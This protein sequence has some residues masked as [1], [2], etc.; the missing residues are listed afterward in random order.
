MHRTVVINVVGLTRSLLG[1]HTPNLNKLLEQST[2]IEPVTPAVTCSAQ[3]TYL[4]GKPPREHGIVGNGWY[5]REMNEVWLWRQSNQ[6]IQ[7]PKV[8]HMARERDPA[9]TCSNTFWWYAMATDAD[10]TLT[11]RP[12]YL[13]DGRKMPDCYTCPLELRE[14]LSEKLGTFPL[15]HFWGPATTI[16]SSQWIADAAKY[17]E[18][19]HKP[20]LQLVYLPH[21][22]YVLQ[23]EGPDGDIGGDLE[24]IDALVGDLLEYF[25]A[26]DCRVMVLSEYGIQNVRRALHPNRMLR[27]AGLLSLKVDLGKEYLDFFS[28]R[29][30]AV[31]DHQIAHIYIHNPEDIPAVRK[32][33]EGVPGIHRVLD[34]TEQ[35]DIG[36]DHERSGELVLL[37]E[38]DTWF[39]YYYWQD[40]DR[41]PDY[42]HTVEIHKKPGYDPC[43]LF[44]DPRLK[45]P[46]L[47]VIRRLAQKK[48]G[49]R[50][51]L[52][53]IAVEPDL[54]KGSHGVSDGSPESTPILMSTEPALLPKN[55]VPATDICDLMLKHLFD[56]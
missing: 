34:K 25:Q 28:C 45:F 1:E 55:K 48:L 38:P 11:P 47:K 26:R 49:F 46:K 5:F 6:L 10:Y 51:I 18:D 30:F 39:T 35:A 13:A 3:A 14:T 17:I 52:D 4:T 2:D 42:A 44:L 40:D 7:S 43:E 9:F 15:F 21:M 20:S 37:A 24:Q 22:D 27:D 8:W 41:K 56:E 16:K 36:L 12:L 19:T 29:A 33:F 32:I 54:V 53:V 23:R 31:A 50:Y